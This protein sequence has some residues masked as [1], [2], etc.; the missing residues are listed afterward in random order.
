MSRGD[1]LD[2]VETHQI[3]VK[4]YNVQSDGKKRNVSMS[5]IR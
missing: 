5:E 1:K 4:G 3:R 2:D